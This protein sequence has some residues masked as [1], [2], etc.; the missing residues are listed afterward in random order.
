MI[1]SNG[2][3]F[4]E[5]GV[6]RKMDVEAVGDIIT[7]IG[8]GLADT[9]A[10]DATDCYVVP[11]LVDIH[12]HGITGADFCDGDPRSLENIAASLLRHGVTAFLGTSM[13][14]AEDQLADIFKAA[15][16]YVGQSFAGRAVLRG[17][18]MEGPFFNTEKRGAQNAAHI[19]ILDF[20]MFTRLYE[21][22][23]GNISIITI[24]PEVAGGLDFV[25]KAATLCKVSLGHSSAD[26]D[27]AC[28]AFSAGASHVTHIFNAMTPFGHREP[29][30]VGA[31]ADSGA[32][33]EIICDGLHIHPSMVRA[34][35]K[36]F[37]DDK[38]CLVSD[39]MR[40]CGMPDGQYGLGGQT[41][42]VEGGVPTIGGS[43][44]GSATPLIECMR[45]AVSFGVPIE[46]ALKAATINPALAVGLGDTIGSLSKGKRADILVL[47][48]GLSIKNIILGGVVC[49]DC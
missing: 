9:D 44:A 13:T 7:A 16:P 47:D 23:G 30:I 22:S 45:R 10:V 18:N 27:T 29:G 12:V 32:Y 38:V 31:A 11:G 49:Y 2:L 37:G 15:K 3:V 34:A 14:L 4:C 6:F 48:K 17:I 21:C 35:F 43:L 1:V 28:A 42:T 20:N 36:L 5:D 26:Y 46:S 19:T 41:V 39:S 25:Q 24:A 8:F 33:V 40:A